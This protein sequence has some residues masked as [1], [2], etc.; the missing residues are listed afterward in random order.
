[1]AT[2]SSGPGNKP[3]HKT[4]SRGRA[5]LPDLVRCGA[6][7][8]TGDGSAVRQHQLLTSKQAGC[9]VVVWPGGCFSCVSAAASTSSLD[10]LVT[11]RCIIVTV[12]TSPARTSAYAEVQDE[13]A[14]RNRRTE[15]EARVRIRVWARSARGRGAMRRAP[16]QSLRALPPGGPGDNFDSVDCVA[17]KA[18]C[19]C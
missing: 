1:M 19:D 4:V 3:I 12:S 14:S 17:K 10:S 18:S 16:G 7:D 8:R 9:L 15:H 11:K 13:R 2:R 5:C 6:S